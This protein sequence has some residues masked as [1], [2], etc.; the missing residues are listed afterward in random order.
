MAHPEA[1]EMR[2]CWL[3]TILILSLLAGIGCA[4]AAPARVYVQV[5]S[6]SSTGSIL[7]LQHYHDFPNPDTTYSS[8][9]GGVAQVMADSYRNS[10]RD[11]L[12]NPLKIT[13]YAQ[14]G[15]IYACGT[16]CG[17]LLPLDLLIDYRSADIARWG[18]ELAY[19][20]HTWIWNDPDHDS[21]YHWNQAADFTYCR[22][23]FDQTMAHMLLDRGFFASSFRSGWH[24][25]DN[26]WQSYLDDWFPYRFE[27]D[28]PNVGTDTTEPIDNN[29]DWSRSPAA[30]VP[31]HPSP[32]DYQSPGSLRGWDS[33]SI[34][35]PSLTQSVV[36]GAF[37]QALAGTPQIMTLFSH[38]KETDY[39]TQ[40]TNVHNMLTAAHAATPLVDFEYLTGRECMLKWRGGT[41]TTPPDIQMTTS[42][43][44]DIRTLIITTNEEIYQRQ[45]LV[46]RLS[47][48]G[49]YSLLDCTTLGPNQW[50]VQ[51]SL[52]ETSKLA[53]GVTDLYGNP[54]VRS[55]CTPTPPTIS[56]ITISTA[57]T[58]ATISWNTSKPADG[59]VEYKLLPSGEN[60][61][62][63]QAPR[64]LAHSVA[65]SGLLPGQVYRINISSEDEC[66]LRTNAKPVYV[67][68]TLGQQAI[69]DNV[70]TGFS[71]SGS[72]STGT[73]AEGRYGTNYRYASTSPTGT[74]T[75]TWRWQASQTG[76]CKIHAWW[77][78][79]T[80]RS[81][82]A[83]YTVT[84]Q[85]GQSIKTVN[86]QING[87]QWYLLD[88]YSLVA[89]ETV[90][91]QLSNNAPTGFVVIADAVSFGAGYVP[92][93]SLGL[94]RLLMD[95]S[96]IKLSG[97][98][99][100]AVF[101]A[102][103]Y[104]ETLGRSA[105]LKVQGSGVSRGD[106]VDL[107]GNMSSAAGERVMTN[108]IIAKPGGT[109]F[110]KPLGMNGTAIR[111]GGTD[112][113]DVSG[114]LMTVWGRVQTASSGRFYVDDGSG[115]DDGSGN[116]G[117]RIDGSSLSSIPSAPTYAVI[118]GVMAAET[119][120]STTVLLV[121]PRNA[122]D[123]GFIS[124]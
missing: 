61:I 9:T 94:A 124:L 103:F 109:A 31:Y 51:L 90:T 66:G 62:A 4:H 73:T 108:T 110:P 19:H 84:C 26:G 28:H 76:P 7:M 33:R 36:N 104:V 47:N 89:G 92:V 96:S 24:Y 65:I 53:I 37:A 25:M 71:V 91:V 41:D 1:L 14:T 57:T 21:V 82:T 42:D 54:A 123:C 85:A 15:S 105:G 30:W 72:W 100:T 122:Q 70:D 95:G 107:Y 18:D 3:Y 48:T 43:N 52:S 58:T 93:S 40:I 81:T 23:D 101:G 119:V 69:I 111:L 67:L 35:M 117:I 8:P 13:W 121:R 59:T 99:V 113:P 115:L 27:N 38:V 20:Y 45:P 79:G 106:I 77:S 63:Y 78:A 64:T 74:S 56:N 49:I 118:T 6:D 2:H 68:T 50:G 98:A 75:A 16:N 86:Q 5:C 80:N 60:A 55:M 88:T 44:G 102:E 39:A 12:G 22:E 10:H 112:A 116:A 46:A 34:Y 87:G 29:Y 83:K 11:S 17:P 114:M 97:M 120:G 32:T